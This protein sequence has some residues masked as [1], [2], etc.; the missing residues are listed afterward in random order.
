MRLDELKRRQDTERKSKIQTYI[1]GRGY[2]ET[3]TAK[4]IT[5]HE[6][7]SHSY[8]TKPEDSLWMQQRPR[9]TY[10]ALTESGHNDS[11]YDPLLGF[12]Q[13]NSPK[14]RKG[15]GLPSL[16]FGP[17]QFRYTVDGQLAHERPSLR[18]FRLKS[19]DSVKAT[20]LDPLRGLLTDRN[21]IEAAIQSPPMTASS[22]DQPGNV[23]VRPSSQR[24]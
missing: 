9:G 15:Q 6:T 7:D 8:R 11:L 12:S 23:S 19:R 13:G 1:D 3:A 5:V 21:Y 4:T 16:K 22:I 18:A 10:D 24:Q 20:N 2:A 17:N 14:F